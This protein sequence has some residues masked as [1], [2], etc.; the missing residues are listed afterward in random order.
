MSDVLVRENV[1]DVLQAVYQKVV[2][3]ISDS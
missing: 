1:G 2:G 3:L